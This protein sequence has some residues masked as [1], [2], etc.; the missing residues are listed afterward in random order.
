VEVAW[1]WLV[2]AEACAAADAHR[3]AESTDVE[4]VGSASAAAGCSPDES[5]LD[6]YWVA[7]DSDPADL[8]GDDSYPDWV[9][10]GWAQGG[11]DEAD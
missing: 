1:A 7:G 5:V 10:D 4:P 2:P 3:V 8:S 11:S 9:E 6:D